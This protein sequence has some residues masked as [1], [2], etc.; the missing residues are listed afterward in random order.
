[1]SVKKFLATVFYVDDS[2]LKIVGVLSVVLACILSVIFINYS[3]YITAARPGGA[4]D[5]RIVSLFMSLL[6]VATAVFFLYFY[7][8]RVKSKLASSQS[9]NT[10]PV[11][12]DD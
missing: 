3:F 4:L 2:Q 10:V 5:F 8:K 1:M 11:E 9:V 7:N 12:S 6:P